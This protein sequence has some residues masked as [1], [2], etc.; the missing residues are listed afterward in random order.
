MGFSTVDKE[1]LSKCEKAIN[2]LAEAG[3]EI[4][5]KE[6][7]WNEN[8]VDDWMIFWAC[9]C[10]RRQQH[11][12]DTK[13]F[14]K[15]D[16][17][18]RFFIEMGTNMDGASYASAIDACHKLGYQLEKF[19]EEAPLII[20]P[21][22]CGQAPKLEGDGFVNGS[23]TPSWVDFTMGINMTRNPAGVIPISLLDSGIPAS[24]QIIGGQRQDLNVLKAM[25]SF[26]EIIAFDEKA[27]FPLNV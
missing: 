16:P 24:L 1:I 13:D 27:G 6:T 18:L 2:S 17:L 3:I 26:E 7:I 25:N 8:P 9:A 20:T 5:E 15:I 12:I 19:F 14:E 10:A 11:L 22:T 4:I 23:E 21:A